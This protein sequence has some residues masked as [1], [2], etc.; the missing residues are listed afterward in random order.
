MKIVFYTPQ[1]F[2][3][4]LIRLFTK[5]DFYHVAVLYKGPDDVYITD[6]SIFTGVQTRPFISGEIRQCF[7]RTINDDEMNPVHEWVLACVG[8]QYG[9]LDCIQ[10]AVRKWTGWKIGGNPKGMLC[11]EYVCEL[12]RANGGPDI[13]ARYGITPDELFI[14]LSGEE[15][16]ILNSQS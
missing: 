11:S 1:N 3:G 5:G 16:C 13:D 6:S 15:C 14:A 10:L 2:F 12:L 8:A 9:I 4:R 7:T